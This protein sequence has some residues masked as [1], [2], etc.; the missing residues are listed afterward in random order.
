MERRLSDM[1]RRLGDI[2]ISMIKWMTSLDYDQHHC[3]DRYNDAS[4]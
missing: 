4:I 2:K 1:E 3:Y